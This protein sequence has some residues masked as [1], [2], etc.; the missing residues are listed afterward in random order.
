MRITFVGEKLLI[1]F[2]D[3]THYSVK[4]QKHKLFIESENRE[5][6]KQEH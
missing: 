2:I 6:K 3:V 5:D 4:H 1:Y